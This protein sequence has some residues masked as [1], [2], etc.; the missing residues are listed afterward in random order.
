M[1]IQMIIRSNL[2]EFKSEIMSITSEQYNGLK[3][4]SKTFYL[5]GFELVT[6]NGGFV[7]LPPEITK[8]SILTI[9]I[10]NEDV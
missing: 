1:K 5:S 6:E 9:E 3:E 7:V 2:G 8:Q 4:L 10:I